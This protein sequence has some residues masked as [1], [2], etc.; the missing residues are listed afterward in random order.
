MTQA[1]APVQT[2]FA[3]LLVAAF[4]LLPHAAYAAKAETPSQQT[5][6]PKET[7]KDQDSDDD[8]KPKVTVAITSPL[9]GSVVTAPADIALT[10][11]AQSNQKNK[12]IR[13]VA[14]F[15]GNTLIGLVTEAPFSLAWRQVSAGSYRLSAIASNNKLEEDD[16]RKLEGKGDKE[17]KDSKDDKDNDDKREQAYK[18]N[19]EHEALSAPVDIILNAPPSV[20]VTAPAAD[21]VV[22]APASITLSADAA[23]SDGQIAQVA[24]YQGSTLLGS[25]TQAP[26]AVTWA[27]A[28]AGTYRLSAVA[29]DNHGASTASAAVAIIVNAPPTVALTAPADQAVL[30]APTDLVLIAQASDSDG[31]IAKVEFYQGTTLLGSTSQAPYSFTL[32]NAAPGVYSLSAKATDDRGAA[33]VSAVVTA[34]VDIPP[35]VSLAATPVD[36]LIAPATLSLAADAVDADGSIAKVAFYQGDTLLGSATQAPYAF[37]WDKVPP[38]NYSLT[39]QATDNLGLQTT[40]VPIA[41]TVVP[42]Q[43]PK[44]TLTAPQADQPFVAPASVKLAADASDADGR[45]VKVAFYQ[46]GTLLGTVTQAPY[47]Y[48]WSDV[49]VGTYT[50]T[51]QATDNKGGVSVTPP[52]SVTVLAQMKGVF[53]IHPDHLGTPRIVTDDKNKTIWQNDPLGEPFGATAP[54]EDPDGDKIKFTLN[55]RFPGQ[56]FDQETGAHYNYFR[57]NYLPEV[58]RYGQG[59][60]IGLNGGLNTYVYVNGNPVSLTDPQGLMGYGGVPAGYGLTSSTNNSKAAT[61]QRDCTA[62]KKVWLHQNYG[63]FVSDTLVPSFSVLSYV[64]G[65]PYVK[66]AWSSTAIS[67]GT[68]GA[69]GVGVAVINKTAAA[70]GAGA[71]S[72]VATGAGAFATTADVMAANAC[73]C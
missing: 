32:A 37:A 47:A 25:A 10:V 22:T 31:S 45:V 51:A 15:Q 3:G 73:G 38:G 29:T 41:V 5:E 71:V 6:P 13:W 23:D 20:A 8:K 53:Y 46:D 42:N 17:D 43:L 68:K 24:F 2:L 67:V 54:D 44:I 57:D 28:P 69:I 65:S 33:T 14:Y 35:T 66:Q 36:D 11:D 26:Y 61:C 48:I 72:A 55:L 27:D 58:G 56:Y 64:P 39:A 1:A 34:T 59:D 18:L 16:R 19:P 30:A 70:I 9:T 21:T 49:P 52:L 63:D 62:C 12:P 60:P 50:V 40:S 4:T 7:G